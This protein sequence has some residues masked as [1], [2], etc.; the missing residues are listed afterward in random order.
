V[1]A[2]P[3][4]NHLIEQ[5]LEHYYTERP[6]QG[7]GHQTAAFACSPVRSGKIVPKA[8]GTVKPRKDA[9]LSTGGLNK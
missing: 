1:V 4:R 9:F 8:D 2:C 7:I 5:Y 6:H 3:S